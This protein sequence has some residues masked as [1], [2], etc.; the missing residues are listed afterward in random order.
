MR[1]W[2]VQ[3][4]RSLVGCNKVPDLILN[5]MTVAVRDAGASRLLCGASMDQHGRTQQSRSHA[6]DYLVRLGSGAL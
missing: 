4:S 3:P 1:S 2:P 6:L 5:M